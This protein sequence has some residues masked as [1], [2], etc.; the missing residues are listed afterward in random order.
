[1][2]FM[3]LSIRDSLDKHMNSLDSLLKK[4]DEAL[5]VEGVISQ[6]IT[7]SIKKDKDLRSVSQHS[8][9]VSSIKAYTDLEC[10]KPDSTKDVTLYPGYIVIDKAHFST[11][12]SLVSQVNAAK[13]SIHMF[14]KVNNKPKLVTLSKGPTVKLN[15]ILFEAYPMKNP[16]HILR[17]IKMPDAAVSKAHFKWTRKQRYDKHTIESAKNIAIY[18]LDKPPALK[19]SSLQWRLRMEK[20]IAKLNS[21]AES[22]VLTRIK[23]A[24]YTPQLAIKH[25]DKKSWDKYHSSLPLLLCSD[26]NIELTAPLCDLQLTTAINDVELKG[27][28]WKPIC[29]DLGFYLRG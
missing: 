23:P 19:F 21:M 28:G 26:G 20:T 25:T 22:T 12:A 29:C 9:V 10:L 4:L 27:L 17:E 3:E 2:G 1:M 5:L 7:Y 18:N 16:A 11:I 13:R 6:Y 14:L 15:P 8:N 24:P